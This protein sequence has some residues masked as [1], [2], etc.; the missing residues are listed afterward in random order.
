MNHIFKFV[1][2]GF[3]LFTTLNS[4]MASSVFIGNG[5]EGYKISNK[6]YV[7]DLVENGVY[8]HPFFGGRH[9]SNF[10]D[11]INPDLLNQLQLDRDLL[12]QKMNDIESI[13]PGLSQL[14]LKVAG[15]Y[16][17]TLISDSLG[18]LP[19]DGQIIK[20]PYQERVQIANRSLLSIRLQR[21]YWQQLDD[22]NKIAL[23]I[24]EIV[25]SMLKPIPQANQPSVLHQPARLARQIT[26]DL[27]KGETFWSAPAQ[28]S[29]KNLLKL[30]LNLN[31]EDLKP[32][33]VITRI[34]LNF[35]GKR[36]ELLVNSQALSDTEI[37][38]L[39]SD[40]CEKIATMNSYELSFAL[41]LRT[42]TL[43]AVY[44]QTQYGAEVGIEVGFMETVSGLNIS[45][46][47]IFEHCPDK[48]YRK[49][50][51]EI[52]INLN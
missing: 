9:D 35:A 32:K 34:S 13:F 36:E 39:T 2:L 8:E 18:L 44:F 7:R 28:N 48:L 4:A 5:G 42:P 20:V 40:I 49:I 52:G 1:L 45:A 47:Q 3:V 33:T 41:F 43:K 30:A 50:T 31:D 23:F 19:D 24:H 37:R 12:N 16:S 51:K 27:F 29:V 14:L 6:L 11:L 26:G 21:S 38:Y 15:L 10:V 46:Y 22:K 25:F 17:W